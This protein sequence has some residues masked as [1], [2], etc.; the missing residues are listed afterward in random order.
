M[1][2]S[3]RQLSFLAF[4]FEIVAAVFLLEFL[5]PSGRVDELLCSGVKGMAF[6][7]NIDFQLLPR[8]AGGE[9]IAAA[10][11]NLG[12]KVF[13]MNVF[14]H[15]LVPIVRTGGLPKCSEQS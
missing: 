11:S 6:A 1:A 4:A 14:L 13:R 12:V 7:A 5:N 2:F 15:S 8:A 10:A 9:R 3:S